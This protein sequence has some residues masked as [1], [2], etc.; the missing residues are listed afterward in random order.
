MPFF[1]ETEELEHESRG[2]TEA[3]HPLME[4]NPGGPSPPYSTPRTRL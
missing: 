3:L 4:T 2:S 1:V